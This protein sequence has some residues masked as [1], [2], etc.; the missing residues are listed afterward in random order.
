MKTTWNDIKTAVY[1]LMYLEDNETAEYEKYLPD[2]ANYAFTEIARSVQPIITTYNV[3]QMPIENLLNDS[4]SDILHTTEDI[5]VT[6]DKSAKAYFFEC[7]GNGTCEITYAD[8][9][10][11]SITMASDRTYKT[12][13]GFLTM[14]GPVTLKFS[15][16]HAYH[17]INLALYPCAFGETEDDIPT[18]GNYKRYDMLEL[19][20]DEEK[21]RMFLSFLEDMPAVVAVNDT[22]RGDF[23]TPDYFTERGSVIY[24]NAK[25][26]GQFQIFYKQ[27]PTKIT[28]STANDF[29]PEI[30][31]E[32]CTLVPLLM[33]W[34]I[35]KDD[36]ERKAMLYFN[37]YQSAKAAVMRPLTVGGS[38][39]VWGGEA[40]LAR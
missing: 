15:G 27:Y 1:R 39:K 14:A 6:T 34:R 8:G 29:E 24:L 22:D 19:T 23:E 25:E 5:I 38:V 12:Y 31:P 3:S 9:G 11:D 30:T 2:A 32:A 13:K 35:L 16:E 4:D 36:D 7:D 17:V 18:Y 20:H 28:A 10:S 21:G 33:A 37:E 26:A 40:G